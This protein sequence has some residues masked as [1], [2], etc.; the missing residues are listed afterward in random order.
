MQVVGVPSEHYGEEVVAWIKPLPNEHL[1]RDILRA[2]C[3]GAIATYKI[4]R[5]WKFVDLFSMTV[6]GKVQKY[7]IRE[8]SE[9]ELQQSDNDNPG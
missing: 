5:Y 3:R 4:P 1:D 2:F 9:L 8:I 7:R 6:T